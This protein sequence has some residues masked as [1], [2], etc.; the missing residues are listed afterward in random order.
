VDEPRGG[1]NRGSFTVRNHYESGGQTIAEEIARIT[2]SVRPAG[3]LMQWDS[4]FTPKAG[5]LSFGDQEEMGLGIRM[6]TPLAVVN[7]GHITNSAGLNDEAQVW[8]K[9]ADWC[10]YSGMVDGHRVGV[11]MIPHP[12]NFRRSWFHARNYGLLAANP[13]GRNA[14]TKEDVSKIVV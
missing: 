4:E 14:F 6:A 3:Y 7:G 12:E 5:Q 9:P 11:I 13:F 10:A 2:I 1:S 8:G